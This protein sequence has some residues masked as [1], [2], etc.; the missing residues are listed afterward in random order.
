[1]QELALTSLGGL[2][3]L[4]M[5][6]NGWS[7]DDSTKIFKKLAKLAFKRRKVLNIL[8]C[9]ERWSSWS[10]ILLTIFIQLKILKWR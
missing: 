5:F 4:A 7:L 10:H 2:I 8:S 1:M 3:I 9:L 6:V